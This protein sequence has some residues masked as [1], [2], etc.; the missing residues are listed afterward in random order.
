M[1]KSINFTIMSISLHQV[2]SRTYREVVAFSIHTVRLAVSRQ[3]Y[4]INPYITTSWHH[5]TPTYRSSSI[6]CTRPMSPFVPRLVAI[7]IHHSSNSPN[8]PHHFI[9]RFTA[10]RKGNLISRR[11][12][13]I[14]SW[15]FGV[16]I[17]VSHS[18]HSSSSNN[19]MMS[20]LLVITVT[21]MDRV[22]FQKSNSVGIKTSEIEMKLKLLRQNLIIYS[23]I[24][25]LRNLRR[26]HVAPRDLI[27][28]MSQ[29]ATPHIG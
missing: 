12:E 9:S 13:V 29:S 14:S 28:Y 11:A 8:N 25:R 21:I 27:M 2:R 10:A 3:C 15:I 19:I 23:K 22:L 7:W 18:P 1:F 5:P 4:T 26:F 16:I 24:G 6:V 20:Y 17:H